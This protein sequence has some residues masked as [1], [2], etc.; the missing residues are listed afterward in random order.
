[1]DYEISGVDTG[2]PPPSQL[3]L[4]AEVAAELEI[5]EGYRSD[6]DEFIPV[7]PKGRR[8]RPL[9]AIEEPGGKRKDT[10][11]TPEHD[12]P[13][14]SSTRGS[15]EEAV[16]LLESLEAPISRIFAAKVIHEANVGNLVSMRV[17]GKNRVRAA[18]Q[19]TKVLEKFLQSSVLV[20]YKIK[21]KVPLSCQVSMGVVKGVRGITDDEFLDEVKS[22]TPI[23]GIR[24]IQRRDGDK[25]SDTSVVVLTFEG[26]HLPQQVVA[27]GIRLPV[28]KYVPKVLVCFNC[29]RYGHVAEQCR[30][31]ARCPKCSQQ[32]QAKDC[33]SDIVKCANCG[34]DH[35]ATAAICHDLQQ[36]QVRK[37]EA[38]K[39]RGPVP[40][41][42]QTMSPP[43][44][45]GGFPQLI[46]SASTS[47]KEKPPH[48][49]TY[50]ET[51][52]MS[53]TKGKFKPK[54]AKNRAV[55][56]ANKETRD[57]GPNR[58][59]SPQP[60]EVRG[61][62]KG[63]LETTIYQLVRLLCM[64]HLGCTEEMFTSMI[65]PFLE[66]F[67]A[68]RMYLSIKELVLSKLFTQ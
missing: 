7:S 61:Q 21:A 25:M 24:R 49:K 8:R 48:G 20:K 33:Q 38:A 13:G 57:K 37:R 39:D 62:H 14:P 63:M 22:D 16:V 28:T 27:F 10:R 67:L 4:S 46:G 65:M 43:T 53:G 47:Q 40:E 60:N 51:A 41:P 35:K 64:S 15:G 56:R 18:F 42:T 32:H 1:M 50:A 59:A 6:D 12:G 29:S 44:D 34:G 19:S 52:R 3:D 30:A 2:Q 54:A 36:A 31:K 68:S 23:R 26:T 58:R 9:V 55:K 66:K 45:A 17:L 5:G 11:P